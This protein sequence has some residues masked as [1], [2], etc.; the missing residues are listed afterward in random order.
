MDNS[1]IGI[2]ARG[3]EESERMLDNLQKMVD[4]F[5][6]DN[7]L[8]I[9]DNLKKSED[10]EITSTPTNFEEGTRIEDAVE[11]LWEKHNDTQKI[12]IEIKAS[13]ELRSQL[14]LLE[15][16]EEQDILCVQR[17]I[18]NQCL[19]FCECCMRYWPKN[20]SA[21]RWYHTAFKVGEYSRYSACV[22][23]RNKPEIASATADLEVDWED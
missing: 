17:A 12:A 3:G 8:E 2:L 7:A 9:L 4:L 6:R 14:H 15:P 21:V 11:T 16:S 1:L 20:R 5:G 10:E 19:T 22:E 13:T 23:C 18:E